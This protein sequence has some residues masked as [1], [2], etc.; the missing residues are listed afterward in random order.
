M[1]ADMFKNI[2]LFRLSISAWGNHAKGELSREAVAKL[3]GAVPGETPEEL[4]VR[5]NAAIKRLGLTKKLVECK[6]Y[7]AIKTFLGGVSQTVKR[8]YSTP[9]FIEDGWFAVKL[10][11]VDL[12]RE[13]VKGAQAEL[14]R[15]YIPA[16][17]DVYAARIQEGREVLRE[18]F[19]EKDFPSAESMAGK[20]NIQYRLLQFEV[21]EGLPPEI[22]EEEERKLRESFTEAR[23]Q[24]VELL[25]T[26]FAGAVDHI[27]DRLKPTEDGKRKKFGDK[28]FDNLVEY[29]EAF[30]NRNP[31]RDEQLTALV[32]KAKGILKA[33]NL[34]GKPLGEQMKTYE[35]NRRA[36][37]AAFEELKGELTKG[38]TEL[39]GRS[40]SFDDAA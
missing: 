24:I 4:E 13:Y 7:D 18:Q 1:N 3:V 32:D 28:L 26:E 9:S 12:L 10:D 39:P 30:A 27:V 15:V 38:I 22:R 35:G 19:K 33:S 5:I 40:F 29:L 31:F 16:F 2:A 14:R 23:K 17:V 37:R 36:T 6:E 34:N 8:M 11:I 25:W 21:A 20:F